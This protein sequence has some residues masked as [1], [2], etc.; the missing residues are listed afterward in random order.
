M[1]KIMDRFLSITLFD[2][3]TIQLDICKLADE[4][5]SFYEFIKGYTK[6]MARED[7]LLICKWIFDF[8]VDG[9]PLLLDKSDKTN[10]ALLLLTLLFDN[11]KVQL[12]I[13][14]I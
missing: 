12:E 13:K 10:L 2:D 7:Y 9:S 11:D 5:L 4:N 6:R 1:R 8:I 3:T 14:I